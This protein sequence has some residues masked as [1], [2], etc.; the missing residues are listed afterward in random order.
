MSALA[1]GEPQLA[2]PRRRLGT[3]PTQLAFRQFL[4]HIAGTTG[5]VIVVVFVLVGAFAPLLAPYDPI[6]I[7][8]TNTLQPPS[9]AHLLG[10][11]DSGRDVLSR[12]IYGT[13]ISL[14][15]GIA[16]VAGSMIVG[17]LLGVMAGFFGKWVDAVISRVFDVLLSFPSI[18]L[19]IAVVAILGPGLVNALIAIAIVNVPIYGRLIRSRVLSVREEEYVAA[20][21]AQGMSSSRILI[22]HIVPNSWTPLLVQGTLGVGSAIIDAAGLGFLGLG[23]QPPEAEWG[24]MLADS[25][26]YIVTAPWTVLAPGL[27]IVICVI[28][29]NLLGDG[30]RDSLDPKLRT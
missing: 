9:A 15:I 22:R 3:S 4:R 6:A 5:A 19:A 14:T 20:S 30:L 13:R 26:A 7:D 1:S 12:L 8:L 27:A 21:R 11:D 23:A 29:F 2:N 25:R 18:L 28:A 16:A 24:K 17:G 10:T